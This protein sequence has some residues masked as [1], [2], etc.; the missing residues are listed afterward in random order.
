MNES[1]GRRLAHLRKEQ[2]LSQK[3]VSAD[4]GISQ[5]LLSHYEKGI[6][7]CGLDF[8]L[9][10]ANYFEVST[11]YLLGR[12]PEKS[13]AVLAVEDLP[14]A[15]ELETDKNYAGSVLYALNKRLIINSLHILFAFLQEV[16]DKELTK[17]V[18]ANISLTV[19]NMFRH[20]Y[21]GSGCKIDGMFALADNEFD[22][23]CLSELALTNMRVKNI[24]IKKDPLPEMG[25]EAF[26]KYFPKY[27]SSLYNLI[28]NSEERMKERGG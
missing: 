23:R 10:A 13:G 15:D 12:S 17:E 7:E 28:Y 24:K 6:R 8:V 19:Y 4:L 9:R 21:I 22:Y 20:I 5:A 27:A 18:S 1:F 26:D 14:D 3:I 11:D 16:G 2:K 25:Q